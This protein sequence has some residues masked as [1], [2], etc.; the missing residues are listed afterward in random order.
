MDD[1]DLKKKELE[2]EERLA[3]ER[4]LT[5]PTKEA[6]KYHDLVLKKLLDVKAKLGEIEL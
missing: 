3:W 1:L 4:A 6:T 5:K 2:L